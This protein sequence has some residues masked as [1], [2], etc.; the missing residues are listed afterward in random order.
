M[1]TTKLS[2]TKRRLQFKA[3]DIVPVVGDGTNWSGTLE[4]MA[5]FMGPYVPVSEDL[6]EA[7]QVATDAADRAHQSAQDAAASTAAIG[8]AS[9]EDAG[10][11]SGDEIVPASRGAGLLQTPLKK[12]A[13]FGLEKFEGY[14]PAENPSIA[15]IVKKALDDTVDLRT[16]FGLTGDIDDDQTGAFNDLIEHINSLRSWGG[17]AR[18]VGCYRISGAIQKLNNGVRLK[19]AGFSRSRLFFDGV[20]GL[21]FDLANQNGTPGYPILEDIALTTNGTFANGFAAVRVLPWTTMAG[22]DPGMSRTFQSLRVQTCSESAWGG[23]SQADYNPSEWAFHYDLGT[24]DS[25]INLNDC[26]IDDPIICGSF[27]NMVSTQQ[28]GALG[29]R[30]SNLT[31]LR[32]MRPKMFALSTGTQIRGQS[33]GSIIYGGTHV[34]LGYGVIYSDARTPSDNHTVTDTHFK[35]HFRGIQ[36]QDSVDP[37]LAP[38]NQNNFHNVYVL[39]KTTTSPKPQG[40]IGIEARSRSSNISNCQVWTGQLANG[41]DPA[42]TTKIGYLVGRR[43]NKLSKCS[44][45]GMH[46]ALKIVGYDNPAHNTGT[47]RISKFVE[48]HTAISF[49]APGSLAPVGTV[50]GS[51]TNGDNNLS[52]YLD[53]LYLYKNSDGSLWKRDRPGNCAIFG[54]ST[55]SFDMKTSTSTALTDS[56]LV[57]QGGDTTNNADNQGQIVALCNKLWSSATEIGPNTDNVA[58][59]GWPSRRY[60]TI[61]AGTGAIN[62][63][64]VDEKEQI[65]DPDDAERRVAVRLKGMIRAFKFK[66]AVA[67]KGDKDARWHFGVIAQEVKAA[68]EAEGLVGEDYAMLC[69]DEWPEETDEEGN[70]VQAAGGRYGIRYE[71]LLAFIISAL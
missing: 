41:V 16:K 67:T 23:I 19:G 14:S 48:Q 39:E 30:A 6:K 51:V 64:D 54:T 59:A 4:D 34:N 62:T 66:D 26:H 38:H 27:L 29:I 49:L 57:F 44:C 15:I 13:K 71:E 53:A 65:R 25:P 61:Y 58:T 12:V 33:E 21:V 7:A 56:R 11:L 43:D 2:K 32:V 24:L 37:T 60:N 50:S 35:V 52:M 22:I 31:G 18:I 17:S 68:F 36:M 46:Y 40:F 10:D 42:V 70:V 9:S 8:D 5:K 3:D 45:D 69:Y 28:T 63:S 47:V 1:A 20:N 55:Y